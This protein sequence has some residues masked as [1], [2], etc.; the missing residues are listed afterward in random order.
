MTFPLAVRA[1]RWRDYRLFVGGQL[2][3]LIGTWMQ[4]IAQSWLIY[5]LTGSSVLLGLA[6][7]M[8]QI[9][10]FL[11]A[12]LGGVVADRFDRRRILICAQSLMMLLALVLAWLTF[13]DLVQVWHI[14]V[15]AGLLG[16]ANAIEIPTRQSFVIQMVGREDLSNAIAINASLVNGGRLVG[17]AVAGAIV[18]A[19]GEAWC[20]LL[21]GASYVGV[22]AA[23]MLMRVGPNVEQTRAGTSAWESLV[24]GFTFAWHTRPVRALLAM[25]GLVSLMGMPFTVLMPVFAD[26]ILGGGPY[27]YGLLMSCAG[28]GALGGSAVLT[29][30][31]NLDGL[32]RWVAVAAS[33]FGACLILFTLSRSLLLSAA[34]LVPAGFFMILGIAASNT[35]IQAMVPD[36]LRGRV[37]AVY[38]MMFMGMAPIGSLL[39]GILAEPVGAPATVAIGGAACLAGGLA[40]GTR[41]SALQA[42]ARQLI[43]AQ[44]TAVPAAQPNR[45]KM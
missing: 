30:R 17:P 14:L 20:F 21:N 22:I 12:P 35:L 32:G 29:L 6:G 40:L 5:R 16:I 37:L 15:L 27:A 18:A 33:S 36:R 25:V 10:V 38:S 26:Q 3:S 44:H 43:A 1:L 8:A 11:L 13:T 42:T 45:A 41:L 4:M 9:P 2:I 31:R 28:L 19:V 39:A 24:E 7:F 23:L 34:L